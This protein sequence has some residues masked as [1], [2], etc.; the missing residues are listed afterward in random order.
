MFEFGVYK[1]ERVDPV[2]VIGRCHKGAIRVGSTFTSFRCEVGST[3]AVHLEVVEIEAY[4]RILQDIDEG[5]TARLTLRGSGW[6]LLDESGV[7]EEA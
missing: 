5:L 1:I 2:V 6:Q 7:L 4:K 3:H